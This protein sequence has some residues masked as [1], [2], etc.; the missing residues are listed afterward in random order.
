MRFCGR[1][2]QGYTFEPV[3]ADTG[4]AK[5]PGIAVFATMGGSGRRVIRVVEL[6]GRDHDVRP[7]FAL[8]EA[9]RYGARDVFIRM[10][11]YITSR[12]AVIADLEA[13]LHP[14]VP[15]AAFMETAATPFAA[16]A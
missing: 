2:G 8:A 5:T 10:D 13:G 4:W 3:A 15:S 14:V 7:I 12:R 11:A 1:S 6:S 9:E 16:A